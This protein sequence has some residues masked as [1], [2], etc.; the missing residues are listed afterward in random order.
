MS[1]QNPQVNETFQQKVGEASKEIAA[2]ISNMEQV[3]KG[4][5]NVLE[6]VMMALIANG[7]VLLMDVPG[8]GKTLLAKTLAKTIATQFKRIQFTPDL[9][10]TDITGV[11]IFNQKE[12]EFE[13][14][15]GPVFTNILLADEINRSGPK[16]QSALLEAMEERQVTVDNTQYQLSK[17]FFVIATQNPIEHAGTYP[18]PS[19]QL[20]RFMMRLSIGYPDRDTEL[21]VLRVHT[22]GHAQVDDVKP[23]VSED[24]VLSWQVIANEIY[25]APV[26]DEYIVDLSRATR[27]EGGA[28]VSTRAAVMLKKA[29]R[30]CALVSGRDYVIPDD[31]HRVIKAVFAHRISARGKVGEA[32]VNEVLQKVV[33]R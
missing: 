22:Q 32:V 29:A 6:E 9:L 8:V 13:F 17:L 3:I 14:Q 11:N 15:P 27:E 30:A 7:H 4:K 25:A 31:I 33:I 26:I 5:Q 18:L 16:T 10:P 19:A 28:G 1:Y 23:S 12:R 20:D 2:T 21:E 24:Q